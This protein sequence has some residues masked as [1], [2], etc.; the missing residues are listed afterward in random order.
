MKVAIRFIKGA[1]ELFADD[2]DGVEFFIVDESAPSDR[3]YRMDPSSIG[4]ADSLAALLRGDPVGD[5]DTM[6]RTN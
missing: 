6:L 4:D 3:V 2:P 1:W 5:K